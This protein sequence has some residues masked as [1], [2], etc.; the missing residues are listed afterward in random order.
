MA[1]KLTKM[2]ETPDKWLCRVGFSDTRN[3][4]RLSG[5][6]GAVFGPFGPFGHSQGSDLTSFRQTRQTRNV[7]RLS[8]VGRPD[9]PDKMSIVLSGLSAV[10]VAYR[11][12]PEHQD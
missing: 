1:R 11:F 6:S 12:N 2:V 4:G 9:K 3:V 5:L 10:G 7:G 8:V